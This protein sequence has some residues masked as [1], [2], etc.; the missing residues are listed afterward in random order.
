[1]RRRY[2]TDLSDAEWRCIEPYI[3]STNRRGRPRIHSLRHVLDAIFYVLRSGCA[4]RLVP[5]EFPPW[6]TVYYWFQQMAYRGHL[7]AVKCGV[8]RAPARTL[9]Q[10]RPTQRGHSGLPVRQDNRCRRRTTR[11]RQIGR[12]SCR[13][14]VQTS[15]VAV[16]LKK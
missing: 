9:G 11:L 12:A 15:V 1:M 2:P 8:A 13:E 6:R 14:R 10:K 16:S 3:T 5:H 7:R 4:W